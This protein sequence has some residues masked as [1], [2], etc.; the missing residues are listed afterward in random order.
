MIH[1][2]NPF[3]LLIIVVTCFFVFG[4]IIYPL[5]QLFVIGSLQQNLIAIIADKN[6]WSACFNSFFLSTISVIGCCIIGT[7]F[8]YAFHYKRIW[9]KPLFS[10]LLLLPIAMPPIVG[11]MSY[12]FLLGDNGLLMKLLG[13]KEFNF[14]GYSAIIAIHLFSFY[15]L[16][17]LFAGNALKALDSSVVEASYT[18]GA[19]KLRTFYRV[20]LPQ[21][22]I[23]LLGASLLTFMASM[24]SFSAP[25]IFGGSRRFLTTEIYYSKVNGDI[26]LSAVLS[27]LL[28]GISI[29]VL[30]FFKLYSKKIPA[31]GK[32]KGTSRK[33]SLAVYTNYSYLTFIISFLFCIL[34]LSPIISLIV[35]SLIP[36][37][38]MM[39]AGL[40]YN[41]S[42]RNYISLFTTNDLLQPLANSLQ[43]SLAAV[44]IT[45]L[46]GLSIA[47]VIRGKQNIFKSILE[48]SASIPY[49][50]PGTVIGICLILSFNQ[51]SVFS[52]GS[53]LVGTFWILPVAYTVRNLPIITQTIKAGLHLVDTSIEEA[54]S[55][56]GASNF[57]TWRRITI[58]LICPSIIEGALL[59][60]INSFGEFVATV[61]L[62]NFSTKTIPIEIYSQMRL[63]NN[64][65]AATFGVVL[66]LLIISLI[67]ITR[68]FT[69]RQVR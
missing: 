46:T 49:G 30:F 47:Q 36:E 27:L 40:N 34:I 26:S 12:L 39:Q 63:Y 18:L 8:A 67:Y 23:S 42:F 20:I 5:W 16:Y 10:T 4:Y 9:L 19:N 37:N 59:V 65:M 35:I 22:K 61:L 33:N 11:V 51:S 28:A 68:K 54:S 14:S 2:Q 45:V 15:P 57:K 60:F 41:F 50:I 17:Y 24:A 31:V 56:L 53:I 25:F 38:A 64:G 6:V 43:T 21:L 52:L 7:Y 62:Y 58:P 48:T 1:R 29:V 69:N 66:F 55:A 3:R 44:T 32:A 13:L